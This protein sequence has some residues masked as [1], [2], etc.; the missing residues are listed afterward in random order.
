MAKKEVDIDEE[1]ERIARQSNFRIRK[2]EYSFDKRISRLDNE[3]DRVLNQKIKE[4]DETKKST[5]DYLEIEHKH[6]TVNRY[7]EKLKKI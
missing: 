5:Q 3:I 2:S 6:D 7:R 4:F 1:I